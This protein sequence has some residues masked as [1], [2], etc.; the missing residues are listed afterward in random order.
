MMD[1]IKSTKRESG[2]PRPMIDDADLNSRFCREVLP[3]E[4][5]LTH[6]IR[7]NLRDSASVGDAR[8]EVTA[9]AVVVFT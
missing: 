4:G 7:R 1:G 2:R 3:L 8:Q 6:F 5:S 9:R